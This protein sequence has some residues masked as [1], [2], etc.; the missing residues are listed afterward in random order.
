LAE[1]INAHTRRIVPGAEV[2]DDEHRR[3]EHVVDDIPSSIF[4]NVEQMRPMPKDAVQV[5][6][7]VGFLDELLPVAHECK[8]T[9]DGLSAVGLASAVGAGEDK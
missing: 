1:L 8:P 5:A 2:V 9:A 6:D 3:A 7:D 4:E